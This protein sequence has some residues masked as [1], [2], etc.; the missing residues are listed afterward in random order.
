MDRQGIDGYS[1]FKDDETTAVI[2]PSI[3]DLA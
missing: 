2:N 3:L 1:C